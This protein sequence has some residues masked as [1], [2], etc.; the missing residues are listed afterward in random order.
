MTVFYTPITSAFGQNIIANAG[1]K[2]FFFETGT[3]TP[4]ETFADAAET[5]PNTDPVIADSRGRFGPIFITGAYDV[6]LTDAED[7][8]TWKVLSLT[9]SGV[10]GGVVFLGGF[11]SSTNAGNYPASGAKGDLSVVT[12]G[13][14]LNPASG[15][16]T[17]STRDFIIA[18]IDGATGVDSDWDIIRGVS[19]PRLADV[20]ILPY[21][22]ARVYQVGEYAVA[23]DFKIYR[24][25]V[26][27]V[28]NDPSGGGDP[29]NWLPVADLLNI[30]TS[31]DITRGLTAAQGKVLKDL[32]DN[33][34]KATTLIAGF[35]FLPKRI[36]LVT[37][38][39]DTDHDIVFNFGT[40]IFNS[41]NGSGSSAFIVKQV[42]NTWV[43][44]S[45]AGGLA[46]ALTMTPFT[47]FHCF[48]LSNADGSNTDAGFDTNINAVNLLADTNVIAAGLTEASYQ[49][50][51]FTDGAANIIPFKQTGRY[52]YLTTEILLF[53]GSVV[54][55]EQTIPSTGGA[56][57][58]GGDT[59]A[60]L[61]V[62]TE[63]NSGV[64]RWGIR[65]YPVSGSND[66][67][68]TTNAQVRAEVG[69]GFSS[70]G[71]AAFEVPTDTAGK[72]KIKASTTFGTDTT[73]GLRGWYDN[74]LEN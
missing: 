14:T 70:P 34:V 42:D 64:V 63:K 21:D 54:N 56:G 62:N 11:D 68:T 32:I 53:T 69:A 8:Q 46:D 33:P 18:N 15:S 59:L 71:S 43:T 2:L 5:V 37:S 66:L 4:K 61:N 13:F 49:G 45:N 44:G 26:V 39:V 29:T 12:T 74:S 51:I 10:A 6:E 16:H 72:I 7:V 20:S 9:S 35:K 22:I 47:T 52:F 65:T 73:V 23:T 28:G 17:L 30:L 57:P 24:A 41:G 27:Q 67:V 31:T 58:I 40:F 1:S 60:L 55:V 36:I 19:T 50:R 25:L 38:V 48:I 3:T